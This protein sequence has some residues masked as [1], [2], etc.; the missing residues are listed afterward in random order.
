MDG[1]SGY[2]AAMSMDMAQYNI[3]SQTSLALL[4]NAM[5]SDAAASSRLI[6][7]LSDM[8]PSADERGALLDVRA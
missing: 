6:E 4:K 8:A 7:D 1:L 5:D 2:I 3:Q